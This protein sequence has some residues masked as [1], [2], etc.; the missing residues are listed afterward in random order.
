MHQKLGPLAPKLT[1][2]SILATTMLW[3]AGCTT[4][5]VDKFDCASRNLPTCWFGSCVTT[6][7]EKC[8]AAT[9]DGGSASLYNCSAIDRCTLPDDSSKAWYRTTQSDGGVVK[10]FVC[11]G[12][13]TSAVEEAAVDSCK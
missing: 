4:E 6:I 1:F 3:G 8:G 10:R 11:D 5:C 12:T 13:C 7:P 9:L 2:I